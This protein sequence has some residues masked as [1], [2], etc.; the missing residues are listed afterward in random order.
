MKRLNSNKALIAGLVV[1]A[2]AFAMPAN[3]TAFDSSTYTDMLS[4]AATAADA[5]VTSVIALAAGIMVW[6]KV[7]GFFR[8]SGT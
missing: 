4:A 6:R 7:A 3:A 1:S 2:L 8:K 5:L